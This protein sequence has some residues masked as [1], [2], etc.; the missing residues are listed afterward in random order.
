MDYFK[1]GEVWKQNR[2]FLSYRTQTPKWPIKGDPPLTQVAEGAVG[3]C[4]RLNE[5]GEADPKV[6]CDT[7]FSPGSS[8]ENANS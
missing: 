5:D 6:I 2:W 1:A 3:G 7:Y 8:F 4:W